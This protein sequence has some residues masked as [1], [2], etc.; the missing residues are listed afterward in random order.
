MKRVSSWI[1]NVPPTTQGH[2]NFF[3]TN[4]K[5]KK[6]NNMYQIF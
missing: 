2:L 1:F 5:H 4:S 3:Y 6:Q